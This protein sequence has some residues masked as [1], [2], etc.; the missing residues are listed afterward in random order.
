MF[1][2][3][4]GTYD[5]EGENCKYSETFSFIELA[6]EAR[7]KVS[8][9]PWSRLTIIGHDFIYEIDPVKHLKRVEVTVDGKVRGL[10]V[11]CTQSG[12]AIKQDWL[13]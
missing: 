1:E 13:D 8:S 3:T 7:E 4:A 11:P 12:E 10:Y 6:I 2:V 9:Y 5:D